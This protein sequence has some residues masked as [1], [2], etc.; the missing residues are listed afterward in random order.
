MAREACQVAHRQ[1][2][3][4]D[5]AIEQENHADDADVVDRLGGR[6]D[7][8][9]MQGKQRPLEHRSQSAKGNQPGQQ[10]VHVTGQAKRGGVQARHLQRN[11]VDRHRHRRAGHHGCSQQPDVDQVAQKG[12][13]PLRSAFLSERG[14]ERNQHL[15][16][17]DAERA[18]DQEGNGE[19]RKEGVGRASDAEPRQNHSIEDQA[20]HDAD[21]PAHRDDARVLDQIGF[22]KHSLHRKSLRQTRAGEQGRSQA[23]INR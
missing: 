22:V 11:D 6:R 1:R 19:C 4:A 5:A 7:P 10:H 20:G 13:N 17:L 18:V 23:N 9:S 16:E 8:E 21:N 2:I 14:Q 3:D 12:P 15:G